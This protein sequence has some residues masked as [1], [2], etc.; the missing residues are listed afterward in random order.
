[1]HGTA[2]GVRPRSDTRYNK[3]DRGLLQV[4]VF[5]HRDRQ[6]MLEEPQDIGEWVQTL[7]VF[8]YPTSRSSV[9]DPEG[10]L[11]HEVVY[12][13]RVNRVPTEA[14]DRTV[15]SRLKRSRKASTCGCP[16]RKRTNRANKRESLPTFFMNG[17]PACAVASH[18]DGTPQAQEDDSPGTADAQLHGPRRNACEQCGTCCE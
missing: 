9:A 6:V 7:Q 17:L 12:G 11:P 8:G 18:R 15:P 16:V 4:G 3:Q 10:A 14:V 1:M 5:E 13:L 2:D